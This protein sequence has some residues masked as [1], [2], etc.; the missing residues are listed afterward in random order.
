MIETY[1]EWFYR[2]EQIEVVAR[3]AAESLSAL[4]RQMLCTEA[5]PAGGNSCGDA[6]S[7][8]AGGSV[9][10]RAGHS[11][12]GMPLAS[13]RCTLLRALGVLRWFTVYQYYTANSEKLAPRARFAVSQLTKCTD[14]LFDA[15]NFGGAPREELG[16]AEA[17]TQHTWVVCCLH[18]LMTH[19]PPGP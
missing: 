10:K 4:A 19:L 5:A 3:P 6:G 17:A 15:A 16:G 1:D 8:G 11:G 2:R 14:A 18:Y 9:C 7:G 13:L 12:S